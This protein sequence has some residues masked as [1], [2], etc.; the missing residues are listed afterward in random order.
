[1][2]QFLVSEVGEVFVFYN[3]VTIRLNNTAQ[4]LTVLRHNTHNFERA[5]LLP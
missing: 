4:L 5:A 3:P 1:M 2:K